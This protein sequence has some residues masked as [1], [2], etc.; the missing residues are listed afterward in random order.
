MLASSPSNTWSQV[1]VRTRP[2]NNIRVEFR[3]YPNYARTA[4]IRPQDQTP[5]FATRGARP[6]GETL[7]LDDVMMIDN[8]S[9]FVRAWLIEADKR[10][11]Y[12]LRVELVAPSRYTRNARVSLRW[13]NHEYPGVM[14]AGQIFF[15]N[16]S[17]PNFS[18]YLN[19]LPSR[20]LQLAIEF[21]PDQKKPK[22]ELQKN[23]NGNGKH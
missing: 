9:A 2:A 18:R 14:R 4:W 16:I 8:Q 3:F 11:F 5:T 22:P 7:L 15:E 17:P 13:D 12:H 20:R 10:D 21:E 1:R 6:R 23:G 19:N